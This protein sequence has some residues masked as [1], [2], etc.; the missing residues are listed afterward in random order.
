MLKIFIYLA[1][2]GPSFSTGALSLW[3]VDSLVVVPGLNT[4]PPAKSH[5]NINTR[6]AA[7]INKAVKAQ[8]KTLM[9]LTCPQGSGNRENMTRKKN[10]RKFKA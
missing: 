4:G 1:V 6:F 5:P 2:S 10:K 7:E 8:E 3:C 9:K